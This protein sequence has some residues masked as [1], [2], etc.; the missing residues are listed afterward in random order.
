VTLN[1]IKRWRASLNPSTEAT[2][3]AAY[4]L[5]LIMLAA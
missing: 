2:N 5:L 4:R 1:E 3:A